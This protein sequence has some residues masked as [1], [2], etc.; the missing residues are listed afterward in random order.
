M[1]GIQRVTL[2]SLEEVKKVTAKV[3]IGSYVK[4]GEVIAAT[5]SFQDE[6][7]EIISP[8]TGTVNAISLPPQ[9]AFIAI[10]EECSHAVVFNGLCAL[11]SKDLTQQV[12]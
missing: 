5:I 6:Y 12:D 4:R 1:K 8:F 7:G 11:C 10:K 9:T 3:K 2:P